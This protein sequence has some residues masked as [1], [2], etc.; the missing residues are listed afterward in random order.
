MDI[1]TPST[2]TKPTRNYIRIEPNGASAIIAKMNQN[3]ESTVE[4]GR[5]LAA[6]ALQTHEEI[7]HSVSL[8]TQQHVATGEELTQIEGGQAEV[9]AAIKQRGAAEATNKDAKAFNDGLK[10]LRSHGEK[11]HELLKDPHNID[12]HFTQREAEIL[13]ATAEKLLGKLDAYTKELDEEKTSQ[14][15]DSLVNIVHQAAEFKNSGKD[16]ELVR[17]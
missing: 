11:L 12:T 14:L 6:V 8:P 16:Q 2:A 9:V 13:S 17:A 1:T 3:E 15:K 7:A 5:Q 10:Y 4:T